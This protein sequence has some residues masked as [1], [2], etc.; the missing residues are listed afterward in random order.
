[1]SL[2]EIKFSRQI[3][4]QLLLNRSK[5]KRYLEIGVS[6]GENFASIEAE[7]K[8][9]VDPIP[10]QSLVKQIIN[11]NCKYYSLPSDDYFKE[12]RE[13]KPF[14]V[15]FVDG[16]HEY[17]QAYR[18][19]I[20]ALDIL[21]DGGVI[22][23]HDCTPYDEIVNLP[24]RLFN[25]ICPEKR[26]FGGA[27]M[28]D[29]WKAIVLLRSLHS[30]LNVFTLDCD[31]GCGIVTKGTPESMLNFNELEIKAMDFM[32]YAADYINLLNLKQANYFVEFL[33]RYFSKV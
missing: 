1:M 2:N 15:I 33:D 12:V 8:V 23:V 30:N 22:V 14:D 21:A 31:C 10:M 26:P 17:K 7:Y 19:I 16:L 13:D 18:D 5:S 28:G 9:G 11:D 6:T 29:V 4:I 32:E 24:Y 20:N 27:W 25:L 3:I